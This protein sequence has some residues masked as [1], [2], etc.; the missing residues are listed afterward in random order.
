MMIDVAKIKVSAGNGGA[1]FVSFRREKN[2]PRGGPDGG[3]G[4]NGGSVFFEADANLASLIDF[5]SSKKFVAQGGELGGKKKR[6]GSSAEDFN[7][8]VP[9]GTL[10][11]EIKGKSDVLIGD[12]S[13]DGMKMLIARGGIGGKGN[14]VFRSSTNRT[15]TQYTKGTNGEAKDIRLELKLVADVGLIGMPNAGKSTLINQLTNSN[16]KVADYPFTT[17]T[18]NLGIYTLRSGK[19][20]VVADIPGLIEGA[21]KGKGLGDDFL[22]HIER[23]GI[24]VHLID[25]GLEGD[26]VEIYDTIRSELKS[27]GAG[28]DKKPEVV[29]INKL[30]ITEVRN[31]FESVKKEFSKRKIKVFGISAVTGEGTEEIMIEVMKVLEKTPKKGFVSPEKPVK[32]YTPENL[33]NKRMIFDINPVQ[34]L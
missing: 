9:V 26:A 8:K 3:N 34:T 28:L 6:S 7:I 22:R 10:I 1:G 18:P 21:S 33:P 30:D 24:L 12:L 17:L 29:A 14:Y 25:P 27:Y 16:A 31:S 2:I 32:V 4:G 19:N 20:I 11:Y 15:P 23:T 5:H 13:E